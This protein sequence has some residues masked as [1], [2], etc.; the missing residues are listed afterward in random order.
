MQGAI[1]IAIK[2]VNMWMW[3]DVAVPRILDT[4]RYERMNNLNVIWYNHEAQW[5]LVI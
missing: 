2:R 4:K 5:N 3:C 1:I